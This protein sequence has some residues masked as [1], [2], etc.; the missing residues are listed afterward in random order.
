MCPHS[1][2]IHYI[3]IIN[4]TMPFVDEGGGSAS[5][6]RLKELFGTGNMSFFL[7]LLPLFLSFLFPFFFSLFFWSQQRRLATASRRTIVRINPR[8]VVYAVAVVYTW[9]TSITRLIV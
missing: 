3:P 1:G 6:L 8:C 9:V 4:P 2:V 5:K 7:P